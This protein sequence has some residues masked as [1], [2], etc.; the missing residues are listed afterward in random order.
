MKRGLLLVFNPR[1]RLRNLVKNTNAQVVP[2]VYLFHINKYLQIF[3]LQKLD[4]I[5]NVINYKPQIS[6]VID[7]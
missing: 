5:N 6:Q 2:K 4:E 7:L 3:F 1:T